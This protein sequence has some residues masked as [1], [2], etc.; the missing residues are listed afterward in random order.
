MP[1]YSIAEAKNRLAEIVEK[2][3]A[4]EEVTITRDGAPIVELVRAVTKTGE[5]S[6]VPLLDEIAER[7]RSLPAMGTSPATMI[8]EMRDDPR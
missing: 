2:T 4:G 1:R 6:M 3:L 5:A 8:R 7:S